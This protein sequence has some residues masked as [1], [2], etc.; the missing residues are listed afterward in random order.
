MLVCGRRAE[1][2]TGCV[3]GQWAEKRCVLVLSSSGGV[4]DH[5]FSTCLLRLG[6]LPGN[7]D[8]TVKII[9][10]SALVELNLLEGVGK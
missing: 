8:T 10:I 6:A 2:V 3:V 4:M 9:K 1:Y 5:P 7:R